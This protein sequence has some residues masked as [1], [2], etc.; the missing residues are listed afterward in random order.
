M[1]SSSYRQITTTAI[2]TPPLGLMRLLSSGSSEPNATETAFQ[3]CAAFTLF[4]LV[5][6]EVALVGEDATIAT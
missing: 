3:L 1:P 6:G 5:S 4:P 2:S